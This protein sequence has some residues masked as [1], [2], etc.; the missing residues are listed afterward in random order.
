VDGDRDWDGAPRF[1]HVAITVPDLPQ[2]L[3]FYAGRLGF[4]A[5]GQLVRPQDERGFLIT[6]LRA[7]PATLEVFTF[8][9]PTFRRTGGAEPDRLGLRAIGIHEVDSGE[10]GPGDVPLRGA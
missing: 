9:R 6:N 3:D 1:D 5:V 8:D 10:L 7:G 4:G 2:A